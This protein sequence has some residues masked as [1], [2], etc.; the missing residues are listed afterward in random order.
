MTAVSNNPS[1]IQPNMMKATAS[2]GRKQENGVKD[3][4]II[5]MPPPISTPLK[6]ARRKKTSSCLTKILTKVWIEKAVEDHF[7]MIKNKLIAAKR[8]AFLSSMAK[9]KLKQKQRSI[10]GVFTKSKFQFHPTKR[11]LNF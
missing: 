2:R 7:Q 10:T 1:F 3:L 11:Q 6:P 8:K 4:D 9:H 5:S